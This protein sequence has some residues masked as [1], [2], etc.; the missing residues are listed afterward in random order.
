[1]KPATACR[2]CR[3]AKRKCTREGSGLACTPCRE[4]DMT[5]GSA[6]SRRRELRHNTRTPSRRGPSPSQNDASTDIVP[7]RLSKVDISGLVETYLTKVHGQAHGIFHAPT[8]RRQLSN[9]SVPR[10]LLYA[11]SA[12]GSKFSPDP[13]HREMGRKLALESKRLLLAD[14]ENICLE[15]IQA[16]ILVAMLSAGN[17]H[18]SSEA[19]FIRKRTVPYLSKSLLHLV[20]CS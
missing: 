4:R 1:M 18:V 15:N 7:D 3:I 14:M 13:Q 12:I 2:Q 10:T 6:D 20:S 19:L 17:C 9:K 5:C 8:L 16:C 11:M